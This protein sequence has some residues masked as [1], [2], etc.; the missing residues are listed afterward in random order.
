MTTQ[1]TG[2]ISLLGLAI[3]GFALVFGQQFH[4]VP[5]GAGGNLDPCKY[6]ENVTG[7]ISFFDF[8]Y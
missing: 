4:V 3:F 5:S 8:N 7:K 1:R 6:F 2:T